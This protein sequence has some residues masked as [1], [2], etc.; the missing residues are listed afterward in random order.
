MALADTK[1][2]AKAETKWTAFPDERGIEYR[3]LK[4]HGRGRFQTKMEYR[5][6]ITVMVDGE[7]QQRTRKA[8]TRS[9]A[10]EAS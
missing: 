4:V 3:K 8:N 9:D 10:R 7:R 1:D 2:K 5:A 6:R